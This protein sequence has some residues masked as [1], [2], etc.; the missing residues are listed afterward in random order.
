MTKQERYE[1]YYM[2][3]AYRTAVL[4]FAIRRKVGA[5]AVIRGNIV[6]H[7]FNGTPTGYPNVCEDANG[8]TL[9]N[10]IHAEDNLIRKAHDSGISLKD[11]TVYVTTEPCQ[12][13]AMLLEV[14]GV[15]EVIY[16]EEKRT[17][18]G[19]FA[20]FVDGRRVFSSYNS[21][22]MQKKP[23]ARS[24]NPWAWQSGH[25]LPSAVG[26]APPGDANEEPKP[27]VCQPEPWPRQVPDARQNPYYYADHP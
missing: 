5:I 4:S 14:E 25:L 12:R 2:D 13:C 22:Y 9:A 15:R 17:N 23:E 24:S 6:A 20:E 10:V 16:C 21:E 19:A 27:W 1:A 18:S 7:G 26:A 8:L 11:A 3:V